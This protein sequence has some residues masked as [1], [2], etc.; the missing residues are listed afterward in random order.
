MA[1][2][3]GKRPKTAVAKNKK[4]KKENLLDADNR[5]HTAPTAD[6]QAAFLQ[7]KYEIYGIAGRILKWTN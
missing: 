1:K 2:K 3:G 6:E 7:L 4:S 5:P